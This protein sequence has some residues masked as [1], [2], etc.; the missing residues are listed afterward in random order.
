MRLLVLGFRLLRGS[1]TPA[2]AVAILLAAERIRRAAVATHALDAERL[3]VIL[4]VQQ[5]LDFVPVAHIHSLVVFTGMAEFQTERPKDVFEVPGVVRHIR[6]FTEKVL[7]ENRVQF[8]V[9]RRLGQ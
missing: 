9:G 5:I 3:L 1:A 8:G 6:Q 4:A 7:T 2:R